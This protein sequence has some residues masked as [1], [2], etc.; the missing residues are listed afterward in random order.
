VLKFNLRN[1]WERRSK[2]NFACSA[3]TATT[4]KLQQKLMMQTNND[5]G[6]NTL[7]E[8]IF[9]LSQHVNDKSQVIKK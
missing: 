9:I 6:N 3:S 7:K 5:L 2:D 4:E 8:N 1:D